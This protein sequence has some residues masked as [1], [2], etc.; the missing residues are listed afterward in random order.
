VLA[1]VHLHQLAKAGPALAPPPMRARLSPCRKQPLVTHDSAH[2][3][4]ADAQAVVTGQVLGGQRRAKVVIVLAQQVAQP[5]LDIRIQ[6]PIGGPPPGP[7]RQGQ[8]PSALEAPE[9]AA[10]L[11]LSEVE[12][13][14]RLNLRQLLG[15]NPAKQRQPVRV[16]NT[17]GK[18]HPRRPPHKRRRTFLL[19][20]DRTFPRCYD[21]QP[22]PP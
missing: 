14:G 13:P 8:R 10:H 2:E 21:K 4:T 16:A 6:A 22:D 9:Q 15:L 7:V 1:G 3:L 12:Q 11:A 17:H 20:Q 5:A 18:A 19:C